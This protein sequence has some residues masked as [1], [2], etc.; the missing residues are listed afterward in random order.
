M[1]DL[2]I[3]G[4]SSPRDGRAAEPRTQ[5]SRQ[6]TTLDYVLNLIC[7][8][9]RDDAGYDADMS[10]TEFMDPYETNTASY[11]YDTRDARYTPEYLDLLNCPSTPEDVEEQFQSILSPYGIK[12]VRPPVNYMPSYEQNN[13]HG[14][15]A[16]NWTYR[17]GNLNLTNDMADYIVSNFLYDEDIPLTTYP[18]TEITMHLDGS[19]YPNLGVTT[20]EFKHVV[21]LP[22]LQNL[23]YIYALNEFRKQDWATRVIR[24][25]AFV[26]ENL[27]R[28]LDDWIEEN[29][30]KLEKLL[31]N[32]RQRLDYMENEATLGLHCYN[33]IPILKKIYDQF[34][35]QILN[36]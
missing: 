33:N 17:E 13:I 30:V 8:N 16:M 7:R 20:H 4:Y 5:T 3:T 1:S 25:K 28:K 6:S 26:K 23:L 24:G 27:K 9:V 31:E 12:Y 18:L 10:C 22:L 15:D 29:G 35:P 14:A 2:N 19:R 21:E 34:L 36:Q 32:S 11:K